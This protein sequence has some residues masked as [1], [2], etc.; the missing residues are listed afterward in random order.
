MMA[1]YN[2]ET[3]EIRVYA[4]NDIDG[5]REQMISS[6]KKFKTTN[7]QRV[8]KLD[9]FDFDYDNSHFAKVCIFEPQSASGPKLFTIKSRYCTR[10]TKQSRYYCQPDKNWEFEQELGSFQI[11]S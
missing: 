9:K 5:T 2:Q 8:N 3:N 11:V 7:N 4:V 10:C 1:V 6:Q